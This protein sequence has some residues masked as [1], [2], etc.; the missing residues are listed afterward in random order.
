MQKCRFAIILIA[1]TVHAT[2]AALSWTAFV[3]PVCGQQGGGP[4]VNIIGN[5][6]LNWQ[7]AQ[8]SYAGRL[9][10]LHS[11]G[12]NRYYGKVTLLPSKG[13]VVT[14]EARILVNGSQIEIEC[15]NP[16]RR[17]YNPDRFFVT[18]SGNFMDGFSI[19]TAGQRGSRI[20]FTRL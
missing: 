3:V 12:P 10:V 6:S 4:R 13:G 14:Q 17:P 20:T 16:S 9:D 8:D 5:W 19:D 7:G 15:F 18:L 1:L 2:F 11:T